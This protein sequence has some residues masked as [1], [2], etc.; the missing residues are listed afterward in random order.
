M[1]FNPVSNSTFFDAFAANLYSPAQYAAL[2]GGSTAPL[3]QL[4]SFNGS[5]PTLANAPSTATITVGLVLDRA[6]DPSALL[7]GN[8]AQRE[9]A[10]AAFPSSTGPWNSYGA[11]G[12]T[13]NA[14]QTA[15]TNLVGVQPMETATGTGYVS[16]AA[17]RTIWL[18]V[19]PAQF[20]SLFGKTLLQAT[21]SSGGFVATAWTGNLGLDSSISAGAVKGLWVEEGPAI[22]NPQVLDSALVPPVPLQPLSTQGGAALG[23]GN[24][25]PSANKVTATPAAIAADYKFPLPASVATAPVALV[26]T[27]ISAQTTLLNAYNQY[28]QQVGLSAV[29]PA[30]FQVLS[31]TNLP[32]AN[33]IS[34]VALD[35]SMVGDAVPN[36]SQLLYSYLP[37]AGGTPF[38]AYQ[39][40]FFD[41]I[42][43][44]A[45]LSSSYP[46]FAQ[47]TA[48]SPFQV[49]YQQLMVDGALAN[50][51][52]LIA[53]G[54]EGSSANIA[55]GAA[56]VANDHSSPFTLIVSGTSIAGLYTALNDTTLSQMVTAAQH[57]DPATVFQL[58][59]S[60]L[61]TLPSHLSA[62]AP[63]PAGQAS[64]LKTLFESVWQGLTLK[65]ETV[66]GQP[67]L[68]SK[69]GDHQ[70]GSGGIATLMDIPSYQ[71]DYGLSSLTD[72]HR[73]APDVAALAGGDAQ[74]AVLNSSYVNSLPN[75]GD[76]TLV[77]NVGGTSAAAPL[78]A[79]LTTQFNTIFHDQG[80]PNLG[81]YNDLLY[82]AATIAPGS[83]NDVQLG[84]NTNSFFTTTSGL[85]Y[86]NN[87]D[88]YMTP[89]GQGYSAT[90]GYDLASGLGT[91]DGTLLARALT[92]IAHSEVS[93]ATVPSVLASNGSGGWTSAVDQTLLVQ[94]TT[95][96]ADRTI[97]V[98]DG[99]T[100]Q[101]F[102]S[103]RPGTYAWTPRLADQSLQSDFDSGL[104]LLFDGHAQGTV[105]Q[106]Q[107]PIGNALS[108]S[109]ASTATQAT[110]AQLSN[111]FGFDDFVSGTDA[112][113][114]ARPVAVAETVGGLNDQTAVVR[115]R[116]VGTDDFGLT[117]YRVDNLS[118]AIN[119]NLPGTAGYQ[120]AVQG[121]AYQTD[122]GAT[123]VGGLD[124]G[125]YGQAMLKHVN[126][127]DLIA[128]QFTNKTTG[129]TFYGFSQA[130]ETVNGQPV[131]H[132][133]NYSLNTWGWE[134]TFGGGD[135]DYNDLEVQIDFTAAYG[136]GWLI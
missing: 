13:Y 90:P 27:D 42:N 113:R 8:W 4:L 40:A 1:P 110:Q 135:H 126:A 136:H 16:S 19:N 64:T 97:S 74:Y 70:T 41:S 54:D 57:D 68:E 72:G 77:T 39:Q 98:T 105:T 102:A 56:N 96:G 59:A 119:G 17:D 35:I 62:D 37:N 121:R 106:V 134:D 115:L 45:V 7:S 14:V 71:Q 132:L 25:A 130:N 131:T 60:G 18:T 100:T 88:V 6:A 127:G 120:A 128:M 5:A 87:L 32:T 84:N 95:P 58:V 108:I 94:A 50:V 61:R 23:I 101:S 28:R 111:A 3:G 109:I 11:N 81:Y 55:N 36:S 53:G 79:S 78:W 44:P 114:L 117:F 38:N 12:S 30:Q 80:L 85:Y 73:G 21:N 65:Q 124:Y 129:N 51:S 24:G 10:L 125:Q 75:P 112:V 82:I 47:P 99:G 123:S 48:N 107:A 116:H 92:A 118:G 29:T 9:A 93:F 67:V 76:N 103:G 66:N 52:T 91:P 43:H 31:G 34:E 15:V 20:Q 133:W 122:T 86:N 22:G 26:E 2:V 46:I 69:F 83:F 33:I 63:T 104:T 89:T 49:A